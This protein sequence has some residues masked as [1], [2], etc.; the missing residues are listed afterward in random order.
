V[1]FDKKFIGTATIPLPFCSQGSNPHSSSR[2]QTISSLTNTGPSANK[3]LF[4]V[5]NQLK[6][7]SKIEDQSNAELKATI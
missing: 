5:T 2:Q 6:S 3:Y 4:F 1:E 7:N